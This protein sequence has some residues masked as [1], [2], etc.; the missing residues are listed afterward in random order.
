MKFKIFTVILIALFI[1][2]L[3]LLKSNIIGTNVATQASNKKILV[4]YFS[5]TGEQR[6]VGNITKG[7][8]AIIGEMIAAK[9][10]ADIFEIK[11]VEDNYP[12]E[13][14]K[15]V[16]YAQKEKDEN[17]RPDIVGTANIE[18][19]DVIFIGYPNWWQ[20][21]PMPVYTFL[22]SYDFSGKRVIPFCTHEG[23]GLVGTEKQLRKIVSTAN[24]ESG[25][26]IYGHV[27]QNNPQE[28]EKKLDIWLKDLGF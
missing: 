26:G 8:T 28:A 9:T 18:N 20:D 12:K 10:G 14:G 22:E 17:V 1:G 27:A 6:N 7:N 4:A 15:F 11:V 3:L 19:Y 13:Y 2:T 25:I 16:A 24:V 5:R 21:L 23:S